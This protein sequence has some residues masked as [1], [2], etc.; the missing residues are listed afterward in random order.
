MVSLL[1]LLI[2]GLPWFGALL[3]WWVGDSH[4]RWQHGLAAGF[5]AAAGLVAL[6]SAGLF[7]SDADSRPAGWRRVWL[8]FTLPQMGWGFSWRSSPR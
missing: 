1:V 5:S 4:P 2:I 6:A 3:V 8:L 7:R